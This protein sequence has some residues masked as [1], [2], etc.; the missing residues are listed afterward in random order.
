MVKLYVSFILFLISIS[1]IA[2]SNPKAFLPDLFVEY[3][4]VRDIA[5]SPD[6]NEIYF[7]VDDIKSRIA[8]ISFISKNGDSWGEPR[9]V[10]FTGNYRDLEPA[11]SHDGKRLFF[12][13]NR[14]IDSSQNNPKDYDIWYV[15]KTETGWS[16]PK[17]IG[18]PINTEADEYYPSI[19]K[20][21]DIYFTAERK[22]A[23]GREDIFVSRLKDGLYQNPMSISGGVNTK[24][25]EFNAFIAPDENYIIFSSQRPNEGSGGGDLYISYKDG[26]IWG[27]SA[28][29]KNVNSPYLDFCPFIDIRTNRLFFT[30][31]KTIVEKHYEKPLSL[32]KFLS[33]YQSGKPKGLNRLYFINFTP[34]K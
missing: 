26:D 3:P 21:G 18:S 16:A 12:V 33:I 20:K 1:V 19:T 8:V 15:N 27:K 31:Q 9:T 23:V 14:P 28:L 25:Y 5:I 10:S 32:D 29:V 17:N 24:Y 30:S 6:G 34:E 13:S 4:N 2:Q 22:D 11:F 7:T